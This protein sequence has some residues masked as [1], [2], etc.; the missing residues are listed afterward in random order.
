MRYARKH[1]ITDRR[2]VFHSLRHSFKTACRRAG[3]RKESHDALNADAMLE[4]GN[5][6]G[7][8]A[9]LRILAAVNELLDSQPGDGAAVH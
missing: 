8:A 6:Y 2:K 4:K 1:G 3:I 5:L 7:R 9:W